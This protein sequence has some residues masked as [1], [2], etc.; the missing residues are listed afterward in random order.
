MSVIHNVFVKFVQRIYFYEA[1]SAK[2]I[3]AQL[4]FQYYNTE[5]SLGVGVCV[6]VCGGVWVC[7][8]RQTRT[9]T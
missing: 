5:C 6:G 4:N 3:D 1:E 9:H 2:E 8:R 7:K